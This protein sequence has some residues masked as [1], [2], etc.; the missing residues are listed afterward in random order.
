MGELGL[1]VKNGEL[2]FRPSLLRREEF[3][4]APADFAYY[5]VAGVKQQLRLPAGTLAFTC[6]QVPV[7]YRLAREN[8]LDLVPANGATRSYKEL[9]LDADR[10]RLIFD[11]TGKVSK[12]EVSLGRQ[13]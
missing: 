2:H 12:I 4:T 5:D 10:S 1:F 11:R 13:S 7:L 3:L 6:C 9:L 8:S